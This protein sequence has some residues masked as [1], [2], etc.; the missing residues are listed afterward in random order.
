M[1]DYFWIGHKKD[2]NRKSHVWGVVN[3]P[4]LYPDTKTVVFWGSDSGRIY[5][6]P[7]WQESHDMQY[8]ITNKESLGY[9][10]IT[11]QKFSVTWPELLKDIEMQIVMKKLKHVSNK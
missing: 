2:L 10:A 1:I 6:R 11:L 7:S 8:A 5:F 9:K 3:I 4:D